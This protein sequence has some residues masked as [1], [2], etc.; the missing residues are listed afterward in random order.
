MRDWAH[1]SGGG[2]GGMC[3]MATTEE[4]EASG[5]AKGENNEAGAG[6]AGGA[7]EEEGEPAPPAAAAAT[8][9]IEDDEPAAEAE[10]EMPEWV[11]PTRE[12]LEARFPNPPKA[13]YP[14]LPDPR[15]MTPEQLAAAANQ[16]VSYGGQVCHIC[17]GG[18]VA[19]PSVE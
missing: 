17:F 7:G 6:S 18:V 1:S 15:D 14:V 9:E 16:D 13:P 5:E 10:R 11:T 8:E 3:R 2:G 4:S 19:V 12:E